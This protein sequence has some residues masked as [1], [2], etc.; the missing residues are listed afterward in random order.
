M[1]LVRAVLRPKAWPAFR[2]QE[3]ELRKALE[4][5]NVWSLCGVTARL[6]RCAAKVA[7]SVTMEMRYQ[8]YVARGAP[9]WMHDLLEAD[10][11]GR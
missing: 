5:I 10:K 6:N 7:N 8:S 9:G 1:D 4:K 11:Q 3:T 2:Y